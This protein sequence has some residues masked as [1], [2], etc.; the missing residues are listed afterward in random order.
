MS[1]P[2]LRGVDYRVQNV[3]PDEVPPPTGTRP[4]ETLYTGLT[5]IGAELP[6]VSGSRWVLVPNM[7]GELGFRLEMLVG[8]Y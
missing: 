6:V 7:Q 2:F 1:L 8:S 3:D 4:V 5:G